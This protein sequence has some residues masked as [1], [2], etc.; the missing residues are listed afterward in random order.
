M[1]E[2]VDQWRKLLC[3]CERTWLWTPS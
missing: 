2:A 3:A 1:D